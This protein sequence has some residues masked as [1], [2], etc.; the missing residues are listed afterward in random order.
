MA[1]RSVVKRKHDPSIYQQDI[2]DLIFEM[3][4][5]R[6]FRNLVINAVAGSGKSTTIVDLLEFINP[7]FSVLYLTFGRQANADLKGKI[8]DF[9]TLLTV[10]GHPP[11]K[12]ECRTIY[13]IGAQCF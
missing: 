13:S 4:K 6:H 8:V 1:V 5:N 11:A 10:A 9:D 3:F 7:R 2:F 12:W